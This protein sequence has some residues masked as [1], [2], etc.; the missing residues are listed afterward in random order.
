MREEHVHSVSELLALNCTVDLICT[1]WEICKAPCQRFVSRAMCQGLTFG[2]ELGSS[3]KVVRGQPKPARGSHSA[4]AFARGPTDGHESLIDTQTR[5]A[6]YFSDLNA[7]WLKS[8]ALYLFRDLSECL[9]N[10][11]YII[12]LV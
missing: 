8:V 6:Q 12:L 7:C 2:S 9:L 5:V 10:L 4:Y 11:V 1:A 3:K